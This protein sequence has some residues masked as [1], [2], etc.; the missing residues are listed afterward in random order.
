MPDLETLSHTKWDC[1]Y[2]VVFIPKYRRKARYHELRRH[3]GEV[4]RALAAQKACRMEEGHLMADHV[5][6]LLSIPPK[7]SVA[8]VVGFLKGKA[9]SHIARTCMGRRKNSTGHPFWA[10]GY[11]VSTVGRDEAVIREYIR[12]Q[13]AD[14]RRLDQMA[15][16]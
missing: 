9:A 4:F 10:R 3:L 1:K 16:W 2:H 14:D 8:Q 11:S 12:T 6:M 5:H 7:Y 13:E 15:L